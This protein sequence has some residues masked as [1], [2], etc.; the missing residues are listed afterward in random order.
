MPLRKGTSGG[1]AGG[2]GGATWAAGAGGVSGSG[3]LAG[4]M[5]LAGAGGASQG[6]WSCN[7]GA[8]TCECLTAT[9]L[10]SARSCVAGPYTCYYTAEMNGINTCTCSNLITAADCATLPANGSVLVAN[11][12]PP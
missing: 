1:G 12:P 2:T 10:D 4:A 8:G 3:G 5:G 7:E 11:C 9:L 6:A